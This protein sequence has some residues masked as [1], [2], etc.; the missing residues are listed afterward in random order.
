M[1]VSGTFAIQ[2]PANVVSIG[3]IIGQEYLHLKI[4]T[5]LFN[6]KGTNID[7]NDNAFFVHTVS[8]RQQIGNGVQGIVLSF[9]SAELVKTQ[10]LK[11][12]K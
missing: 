11:V 4:K 5:P 9:V 6:N 8:K 10:R 12:T 1:S 7:F 3:P 2:D